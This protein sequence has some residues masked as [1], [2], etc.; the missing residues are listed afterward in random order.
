M[1]IERARP[2]LPGCL[3]MSA[4]NTSFH[5][6]PSVHCQAFVAG[7]VN[8]EA[9]YK[10]TDGG[11]HDRDMFFIKIFT[12]KSSKNGPPRPTSMDMPYR[13]TITIQVIHVIPRTSH[14]MRRL[15]VTRNHSA[16]CCSAEFQDQTAICGGHGNDSGASPSAVSLL[17]I[18]ASLQPAAKCY[19]GR[20]MRMWDTGSC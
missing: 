16:E 9:I 7:K 5:V 4:M 12:S 19:I 10:R 2:E 6:E 14:D 11:V 17:A 8:E 18:P 13:P 1:V 15:R 20:R 3:L